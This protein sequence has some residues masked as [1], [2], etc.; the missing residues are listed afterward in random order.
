M[1][2]YCLLI[3]LIV[4]GREYN[5]VIQESKEE[6]QNFF[7][8][9]STRDIRNMASF[10]IKITNQDSTLTQNFFSSIIVYVCSNAAGC[11]GLTVELSSSPYDFYGEKSKIVSSGYVLLSIYFKEIGS[12]TVTA[13]AGKNENSKAFIVKPFLLSFGSP[14]NKETS[15][16]SKDK[17]EVSVEVT[18]AYGNYKIDSNFA[19]KI[20]LTLFC[21]KELC[22]GKKTSGKLVKTTYSNKAR[23]YL[24]VK[25]S[26]IFFF[27]AS[28]NKYS[29]SGYSKQFHIENTLKSLDAK[30]STL[31]ESTGFPIYIDITLVGEDNEF[32]L[33]QTLVEI[34]EKHNKIKGD[35]KNI[36]INGKIHAK[37]YFLYKGNYTFDIICGKFIKN[38]ENV[39]IKLGYLEVKKYTDK[40]IS[41]DNGLD[42]V[43]KLYDSEKN[44][45]QYNIP[46]EF[47]IKLSPSSKVS[48]K[49]ETYYTRNGKIYTKSNFGIINVKN[50]YIEKGNTY[51]IRFQAGDIKATIPKKYNIVRPECGLGSGPIS[52]YCILIVLCISF[53]IFFYYTD[54]K[55]RTLRPMRHP[56]MLIHPLTSFFFKQPDLRRT[57]LCIQ[58]FSSELLIISTI[59]AVYQV[60]NKPENMYKQKMSDYDEKEIYKGA[61]GWGIS[62]IFIIPIFFLNWWYINNRKVVKWSIGICIIVI[63]V[64]F[65]GVSY[66]TNRYCIGFSYFWA[67]NFMIFWVFDLITAQLIYTII[68][69]NLWSNVIINSLNTGNFNNQSEIEMKNYDVDIIR[70]DINNE[71]NL[72][73]DQDKTSR[74]NEKTNEHFELKK[75]MDNLEEK[76]DPIIAELNISEDE[77]PKYNQN[78][79]FPEEKN[80]FLEF[81]KESPQPAI[82]AKNIDEEDE[83]LMAQREN[84][85]WK[86]DDPNILAANNKTQEK[87][88]TRK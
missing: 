15:F 12:V 38:I 43:L 47:M 57:L 44:R 82:P 4:T 74:Q 66:M 53:S 52:S 40:E 50:F 28:C 80:K 36:N 33:N 62:Q 32:Y 42:F 31:T 79:V 70:Y 58:V 78:N 84:V 11:D 39:N 56:I 16:L 51:E 9:S 59:G 85:E 72:K 48:Y 10:D 54:R 21:Q 37:V 24:Y 64:C 81:N 75:M 14:L 7:N 41:S 26:G 49:S 87:I 34:K 1:Y 23:F 25:S 30:L 45:L 55:V 71:N 20:E 68:C 6:N 69:Y 2:S 77:F 73:Q 27:K 3:F 13:K 76:I 65:A 5:S 83:N 88:A 67:A 8:A 18:D 17:I 61:M 19:Y 29:V 46:I 35:T 86:I 60:F 63:I 22:S